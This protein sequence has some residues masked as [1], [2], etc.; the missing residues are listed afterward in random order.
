[1]IRAGRRTESGGIETQVGTNQKAGLNH[2]G[3]ERDK[4]GERKREREEGQNEEVFEGE[5]WIELYGRGDDEHIDA[6]ISR[7]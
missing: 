7:A 3:T 5:W 6:T 2:R 1:M 4:D